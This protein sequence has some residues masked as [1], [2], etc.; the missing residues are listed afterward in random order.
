MDRTPPGT[1]TLSP[2]VAR[3]AVGRK[4]GLIGSAGCFREPAPAVALVLGGFL[5]L[6][7]NVNAV[8]GHRA[9]VFKHYYP[10]AYMLACIVAAGCKLHALPS[11]ARGRIA[12][13]AR[14]ALPWFLLFCALVGASK[15]ASNGTLYE[16]MAS[17]YWDADPYGSTSRRIGLPVLANVLGFDKNGY[18]YV[19]YAVLFA[20]FAL[21]WRYLEDRGLKA[22]ERVSVLSSSI[23][24]Y[25]LIGPGYNEVFVFLLG[26]YALRFALGQVEKIVVA[27]LMVATHETATPFVAL[28]VVLSC[29]D[30]ERGAWL[31]ILGALYLAYV[32]SYLLTWRGD[33]MGALL[34]AGKPSADAADTSV[35]LLLTY[36]VRAMLGV[37]L[38]YKLYWAVVLT[39]LTHRH[40]RRLAI[41][42]FPSLILA[43]I[44]TDTSRLVQ[45]GSLAFL[46]AVSL[47]LPGLPGRW[48]TRLAVANLI[49]PSLYVATNVEPLWGTGLYSVYLYGARAAGLDWG[50]LFLQ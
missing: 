48:R 36:P 1:A 26:L 29:D 43:V 19:W 50:R 31:S 23:F 2:P 20:A 35:G 45:F 25:S 21:A 6:A 34:K 44:G 38:A 7:C 9:L 22:L 18:I 3:S 4:V 37:F 40:C 11:Q 30:E 27:T 14:S 8:V 47:R 49:V 15:L 42:V 5:L 46:A 28:A 13:A 33:L 32:A 41:A 39:A 10:H 12:G 16:A 24:A 17:N